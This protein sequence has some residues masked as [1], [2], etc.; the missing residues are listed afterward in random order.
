M[1]TKEDFYRFNRMLRPLCGLD[2]LAQLGLIVGVGKRNSKR[3]RA[4][5]WESAADKRL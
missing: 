1:K 2:N 4:S 5:D 3:I